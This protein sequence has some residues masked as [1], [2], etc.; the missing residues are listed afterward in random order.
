METR[1]YNELF[2]KMNIQTPQRKN[3]ITG[4]KFFKI[5]NEFDPAHEDY[6]QYLEEQKRR[7]QNPSRKKFCRDVLENLDEGIRES[8]IAKINQIADEFENGE[9]EVPTKVVP[10]RDIFDAPTVVESVHQAPTE[11]LE[12]REE[13]TQVAEVTTIESEPEVIPANEETP[14]KV[15]ISYAWGEP[16][17]QEWVLRVSEDLRKNGVDTILD[18]YEILGGRNLSH[19]MEN[20]LD[21]ADKVLIILTKEYK[22]KALGR[23]KGA[24]IEYSIITSEISENIAGNVKYIPVLRGSKDESTPMFLR[25]YSA[26]YMK[27][28]E[29]YDEQ[30]KELL[31]SIFDKPIVQK[32]EI[33]AKP[34]FL[35]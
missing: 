23:T 26:V 19:F 15:F 5:I 29:K 10:A 12:V 4:P 9:N 32:S 20:S 6:Y 16:E 1:E 7:G 13:E 34:D 8:V 27:D 35:K 17:H 28:D 33:G 11:T 18:K 21:I 31:H 25:Q 22:D 14:P 30:I 2:I 3:L 24:G